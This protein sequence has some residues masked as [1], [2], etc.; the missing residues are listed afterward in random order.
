[1]SQTTPPPDK[2]QVCYDLDR[3]MIMIDHP[4][5]RPFFVVTD[6]DD[7]IRLATNLQDDWQWRSLDDYLCWQSH[8]A[9]VV[10]DKLQRENRAISDQFGFFYINVKLLRV[11]WGAEKLGDSHKQ[12]A[13]EASQ[14]LTSLKQ[15][16]DGLTET[17][18][19][20]DELPDYRG[21]LQTYLDYFDFSMYSVDSLQRC[22][23]ELERHHAY[24]EWALTAVSTSQ[25]K[26]GRLT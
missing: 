22:V 13:K 11:D 21:I 7:A 9:R 24:L 19:Q 26:E 6:I 23:Q 16:H 1:M 12:Y 4:T 20:L 2:T 17:N 8:F 25:Y 15:V 14:M 5:C 3:N 10:A 18:R